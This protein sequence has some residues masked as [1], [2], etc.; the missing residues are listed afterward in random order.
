M[1]NKLKSKFKFDEI[2]KVISKKP[3]YATIYGK[4]GIISG[5]SGTDEDEFD[6]VAYSVS[7][8]TEENEFEDGWFLYEADL[9]AT[10]QFAEPDSFMTSAIV[11]IRTDK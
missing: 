3:E 5:V 10:G 7:I 1:T 11:K 9:E 6:I 2:V 4:R 8:M